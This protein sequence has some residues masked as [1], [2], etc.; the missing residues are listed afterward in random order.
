MFFLSPCC[1]CG[2]A[3]LLVQLSTSIVQ[4]LPFFRC[5][6]SASVS[7]WLTC[8][9][10]VSKS[11]LLIFA[12]RQVVVLFVLQ[13]RLCKFCGSV[14]RAR[15][16]HMCS[17]VRSFYE[18]CQLRPACSRK[19]KK[20]RALSLLLI[21]GHHTNNVRSRMRLSNWLLFFSLA[22]QRNSVHSTTVTFF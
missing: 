2:L 20:T 19:R 17:T 5:P 21:N 18:T 12:R 15:T 9:L 1:L 14:K 3:F 7:V 8:V 4:K 10:K 13:K 6:P 16:V 22:A 11:R